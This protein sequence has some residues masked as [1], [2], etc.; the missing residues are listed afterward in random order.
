MKTKSTVPW[1]LNKNLFLILLVAAM[2]VANVNAQN[3]CYIIGQ[4]PPPQSLIPS[5]NL[6]CDEWQRYVPGYTV[7]DMSLHPVHKIRLSIS[8]VEN[9]AG[10]SWGNWHNVHSEDLAW[11]QGFFTTFVNSVPGHPTISGLRNIFPDIVPNPSLTVDVWDS[12]IE[13]VID[14]LYYIHDDN[15]AIINSTGYSQA[16][17]NQY[18]QKPNE[19]MNLFIGRSTV[20]SGGGFGSSTLDGRYFHMFNAGISHIKAISRV[21]EMPL[22]ELFDYDIHEENEKQ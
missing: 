3:N 18:L 12:G 13:I 17:Y 22:H 10:D 21:Y 4:P 6:F 14:D 19:T 15:Y 5:T 8:I 11:L 7:L 20:N 1:T 2:S 9:S 16:F